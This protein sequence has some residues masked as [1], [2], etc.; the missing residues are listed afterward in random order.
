[1]KPV[2][3]PEQ[4][5]PPSVGNTKHR[6]ASLSSMIGLSAGALGWSS[7]ASADDEGRDLQTL[8]LPDTYSALDD[9]TVILQLETGEQLT[10]TADQY[11]MLDGG[12][13][14]VVDELAQNSVAELPVL[15]S[16]RTQLFTE[17]QPVRS[18]DG[19]IVEASNQQ[20][21]W[22]GEGP[23]PRLFEEID[24]QR[25]EIAQD[26]QEENEDDEGL[27]LGGAGGALVGI[28]I[29]TL[30][31]MN[32][33]AAD[34]EDEG[35]DGGDT[36]AINFVSG[37]T[38][39]VFEQTTGTLYTAQ[40]ASTN[41]GSITY[42]I[43]GGA[44]Q[45]KF[46]I[47][48]LTGV[49]TF[50]NPFVPDYDSP[51]DNGGDNFYDLQI[52]ATD[53]A[54]DTATRSLAVQ[55]LEV[56]AVPGITGGSMAHLATAMGKLYYSY[57]DGS[58]T[59]LWEFDPNNGANGTA[60]QVA[61]INTNVGGSSDPNTLIEYQGD[62]GALYFKANDGGNDYVYKYDGTTYSTTDASSVTQIP[63]LSGSTYPTNLF[64]NPI[65]FNDKLYFI[66]TTDNLNYPNTKNALTEWNGSTVTVIAGNTAP[67]GQN[68][69]SDWVVAAGVPPY[70]SADGQKL[71]VSA[72][73]RD[74]FNGDGVGQEL[75]Y[76]D[77]NSSTQNLTLA[78]SFNL[79]DS[80]S[81]PSHSYPQFMIEYDG[82]LFTRANSSGTGVGVT[83]AEL[84][85]FDPTD[86]S[87]TEYE[88]G[89][90][91]N[92]N[93]LAF[94]PMIVFKDK[95]YMIGDDNQTNTGKELYV[96]DRSGIP[97]LVMDI[98]QVPGDGLLPDPE[99][100]EPT[101]FNDKLYFIANDGTGSDLWVYDGISDSTKAYDFATTS[102]THLTSLTVLD[103]TLFFLG[104]NPTTGDIDLWSIG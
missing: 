56:S 27:F 16:L 23:A 37:T 66:N 53:S 31:M 101:I 99:K 2:L 11:V 100:W 67:S 83:N 3:A 64:K 93:G 6:L 8:I 104:E 69:N 80:D 88:I 41:A 28:G 70:G 18:P 54:G 46:S 65:E 14:L 50:Q 12:L 29:T 103:D 26:Q 43:I 78:A 1:M 92:H 33:G 17:V 87:K 68:N 24:I 96:F 75:F 60:Q 81:A 63:Q 74:N 34:G 76:W 40:A 84:W 22:S 52:E 97:E 57:D 58:D 30:G 21:L 51:A 35:T 5:G 59:E 82:S 15:G 95:L 44:D 47:D 20:P 72:Y 89:S 61:N 49:L 45:T 77:A 32:S 7:L 91:T 48:P 38:A 42:S 19:S 9:G 73:R 55:V 4:L 71:Y 13:L 79:T 10:L 62:G 25:F 85:E 94:A 102:N 36:S 39:K 90:A 98:N 86:N